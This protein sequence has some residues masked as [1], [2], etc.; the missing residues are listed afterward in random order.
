MESLTK[1]QNV[2]IAKKAV[3]SLGQISFKIK[4]LSSPVLV[5]IIR[6][7]QFGS[8]L[9]NEAVKAISKYLES[10]GTVEPNG[11]L[12]KSSSLF[13]LMNVFIKFA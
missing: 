1:H 10:V 13:T 5:Q 7:N 3:C 9:L 11:E 4:R 12:S 6:K 2:Q 8:E